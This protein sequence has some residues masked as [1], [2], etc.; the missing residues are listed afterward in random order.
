MSKPN[1]RKENSELKEKIKYI[2]NLIGEKDQNIINIQTKNNEIHNTV[3]E[4][5]KIK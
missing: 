2:T 3:K 1:L 4:K 5:N